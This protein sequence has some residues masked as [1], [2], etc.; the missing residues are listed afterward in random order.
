VLATYKDDLTANR[1][2]VDIEA[3]REKV[4]IKDKGGG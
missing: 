2:E 1:L 3:N 4:W